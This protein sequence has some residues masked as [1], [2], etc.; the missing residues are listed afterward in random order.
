MSLKRDD[1]QVLLTTHADKMLELATTRGASGAVHLNGSP[2]DLVDELLRLAHIGAHAEQLADTS[3]RATVTSAVREA[4]T[5]WT[6]QGLF[7]LGRR[8]RAV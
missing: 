8:R 7:L 1:I 3:P 4:S 2:R 6:N 5:W